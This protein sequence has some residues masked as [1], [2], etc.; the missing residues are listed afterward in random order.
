MKYLLLVGVATLISSP[1]RAEEPAPAT[2]EP[3]QAEVVPAVMVAQPSNFC[4]QD[5]MLALLWTTEVGKA[6]RLKQQAALIEA[7]AAQVKEPVAAP[8][9][10]V[11][12]KPSESEA[13]P[14]A[15]K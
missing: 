15:I 2:V 5:K 10:R 4:G 6:L 13:A 7:Q 1:L 9:A 12:P 8:E 11:A 3:V 14:S